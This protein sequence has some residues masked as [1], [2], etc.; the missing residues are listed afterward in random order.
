MKTPRTLPAVVAAGAILAGCDLPTE[1]PIFEPRWIIPVD[2][3]TLSVE[4]LLP[5][6][7][8]VIGDAFDVSV[9]A[10]AASE[11]LGA[12]CPDCVDSGGVPVP[13][14]AFS[15]SFAS[16]QALPAD[17]LEAEVTGGTVEITITNG[18]SFD[19][20]EGGGT[21][22]IVLEDQASGQEIGRLDLVG[23]TDALA[24]GVPVQR[25]VALS[26]STISGAIR[27]VAEIDAPGGQSAPID[28]ADEIAVIADVTSLLVGSV[29]V[30]VP[31]QGVSI[32]EQ[33]I[34]LED[35]P[36]EVVERI[37]SGTIV[38]DVE[39]PFSVSLDG[40]VELGP[41]SRSFSVPGSGP[42]TSELSYTGAELRSIVGQPGVTLSGSGVAN[43]ASVTI[44]P[45]QVMVLKATLDITLEIG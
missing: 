5:G 20:L 23:G 37:V 19:P 8:S 4:E 39:N 21:L 13:V 28:T 17:V 1:P 45:G 26:E 10:V 43:G 25:T 30:D 9:D 38:L 18:F 24:P 35:I 33:A 31:T 36:A 27:A 22:A 42:S 16:S 34:A 32:D 14:P 15:G 44:R 12:L 2:E 11:T 7:V 29:T 40:Q 41:T 3:T 6:G